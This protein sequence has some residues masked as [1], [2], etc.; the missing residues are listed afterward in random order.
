MQI[1][2][3]THESF[4]LNIHDFI[5]C[6][7]PFQRLEMFISQFLHLVAP[8]TMETDGRTQSQLKLPLNV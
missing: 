1:G 3:S 2:N 7:L 6:S 8:G 5:S 4:S